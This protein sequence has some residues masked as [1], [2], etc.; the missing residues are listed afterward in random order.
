MKWRLNQKGQVEHCEAIEIER[1]GL[2]V[3]K[4][5]LSWERNFVRKLIMH[6]SGILRMSLERRAKAIKNSLGFR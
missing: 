3:K 6:A 5:K 2:K 4:P 1:W